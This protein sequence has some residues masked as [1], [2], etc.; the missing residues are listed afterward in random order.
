MLTL[1]FAILCAAVPIGAG[2]AAAAL[3]GAPAKPPPRLLPLVHGLLGAAGLAVLIAALHH[4]LP[5]TGMGT[6][7][8][9]PVA[10]VLL[11]LAFVLG[12]ALGA[13]GRGR[14]PPGPL[15]GV[16]ASLAI[17]GFVVLLALIALGPSGPTVN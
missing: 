8:F 6:S 1:S 7:G 9:G 4:G 3:R 5:R 16:H 10:A 13:L 12:L 17:A 15:V 11:G 14:R 2:L